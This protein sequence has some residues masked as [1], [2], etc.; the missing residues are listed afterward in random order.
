MRGDIFNEFFLPHYIEI[1]R[2]AL[3]KEI[4]GLEISDSTDLSA[5]MENLEAK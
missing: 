1:E 4:D 5:L 2:K 3:A